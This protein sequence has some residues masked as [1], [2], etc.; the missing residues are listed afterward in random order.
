MSW[1]VCWSKGR[2]VSNLGWWAPMQ[3]SWILVVMVRR[4]LVRSPRGLSAGRRKVD[5][6][7]LP[8]CLLIRPQGER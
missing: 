3:E 7:L 4:K 8:Q 6:A 5:G 1:T 2:L